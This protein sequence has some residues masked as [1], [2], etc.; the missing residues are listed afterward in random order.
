MD[1]LTNVIKKDRQIQIKINNMLSIYNRL[2]YNYPSK[3]GYDTL[4]QSVLPKKL[5]KLMGATITDK[6]IEIKIK[7]GRIK[8]LESR[9]FHFYY[10]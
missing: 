9:L 5:I 4:I 7:I 8:Y 1:D 6:D 10:I 3:I 2:P